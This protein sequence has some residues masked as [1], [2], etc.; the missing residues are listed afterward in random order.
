LS[1][2]YEK[3][4]PTDIVPIHGE[5]LFLR[6]HVEYIKLS[7]PQ[8]TAHF[9]QNF[10]EIQIDKALNLKVIQGNKKEPLIIHGKHLVIEREKISERRKLACNGCIFLTLRV[11]SFKNKIETHQHQFAGLPLFVNDQDD[12]FVK[13]L[14]NQLADFS[15]KD[16]EKSKEDLRVA[17]RR[18]FDNIIGYKPLTF[19]HL[20]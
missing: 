17:I 7:Y 3:F 6:A 11:N 13:F 16:P 20:I 5:T 10:D 4:C 2:L 14:N 19:I 15:F 12:H 8:A 1:L 9:L 18:Y